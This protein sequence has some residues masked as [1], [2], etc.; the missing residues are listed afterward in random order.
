MYIPVH[1][2]VLY[3]HLNL[4]LCWYVCM[5]IFK[6][7]TNV[8]AQTRTCLYMC[9]LVSI[10]SAEDDDDVDDGGG[11]MMFMM[12]MVMLMLIMMIFQIMLIMK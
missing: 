5:Y 12:T 8:S 7:C 1:T 9:V 4:E 2:C 11:F 3:A 10:D 6:R